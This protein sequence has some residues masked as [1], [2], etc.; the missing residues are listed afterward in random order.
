MVMVNKWVLNAV[1]VPLFFLLVQLLTAV[2]LLH[3]TACFGLFKV[4]E[5]RLSICKG[6]TPLIAINCIGLAFNTYCLQFVDASFYQVARGLVLPF[7]TLLSYIFLNARPSLPL[8]GAIGIV[9]FGFMV[10]VSSEN[11]SVSFIGILLGVCSS[12]TTAG[13]AI[14]VKRSL[15]VVN[16]SAM[17][18]AY[19]SNFLSAFIMAPAALLAETGAVLNMFS[20]GGQAF[21]TF[22][23]GGLVTGVFGFL[24]C[25]AGFISIKVTSPV[26]HMMSAAVRGVIQTVLGVWLFSDIV[27]RARL[28]GIALILTGSI[29]YTF[30][31]DQEMRKNSAAAKNA[32]IIAMASREERDADTV[33]DMDDESRKEEDRALLEADEL[34]RSE[35][36]RQTEKV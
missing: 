10:G 17:D 33:F 35:E 1:P 18:L 32:N 20:Q 4:P 34:I 23:V 8:L 7:T 16:G 25:I 36:E 19:Y 5:I 31:K 14:V 13:H 21:R 2:F 30:L 22:W 29:V 15:P 11:L 9:C 27:T 28:S 3:V 26:T 6:L 24:I 12:V